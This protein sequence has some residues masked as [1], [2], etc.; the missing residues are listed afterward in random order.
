MIW[1]NS[2]TIGG[3]LQVLTNSWSHDF[4]R[5]CRSMP[6]LSLTTHTTH[7]LFAH[8][9]PNDIRLPLSES[10]AEAMSRKLMFLSLARLLRAASPMS[11]PTTSSISNCG[12]YWSMWWKR[13]GLWFF[14]MSLKCLN[15]LQADSFCRFVFSLKSMCLMGDLPLRV[16][17]SKLVN[18]LKPSNRASPPDQTQIFNSLKFGP[19]LSPI[20]PIWLSIG[21][22]PVA[23]TDSL[24]N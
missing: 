17:V 15:F 21:V 8:K 13:F 16:R 9:T 4:S 3:S 7:L 6:V 10:R 18:L 2:H 11:S 5:V 14:K 22:S 19:N 1:Q 23:V 12:K 20:S 24:N